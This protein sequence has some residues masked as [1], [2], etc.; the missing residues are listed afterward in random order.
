MNTADLI[1]NFIRAERDKFSDKRN[2]SFAFSF[3]QIRRYYDFLKNIIHH[4]DVAN[5][6]FQENTRLMME[7]AKTGGKEWDDEKRKELHRGYELTTELHLQMESFYLFAK[8]LLDKISQSIYFYFGNTQTNF[9]S[10]HNMI[11]NFQR[12]VSEKNLSSPNDL[13]VQMEVLQE[14]ISEFRDQV[15]VHQ[16]S[17][18]ATKAT[19]YDASG[20]SW[21]V[22]TRVEPK[23]GERQREGMS[24]KQLIKQID[25]YILEVLNYLSANK[26]KAYYGN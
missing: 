5:K 13:F 25:D 8:I 17:P 24:P 14:K 19:M 11:K 21:L 22:D 10:H 6:A 1:S 2:N 12:Y 18:R 20:E 7:F 4:C 16:Y 15:I 26:D 23:E 9:Q 3:G